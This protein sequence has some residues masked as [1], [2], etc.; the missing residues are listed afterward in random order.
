VQQEHRA[1]D[2]AALEV[3]VRRL[4]ERR[5][6][7]SDE[8]RLGDAGDPGQRGDGERLG[9]AAVHRVA[10]AEQPAVAL[11]DGTAHGP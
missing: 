4:A 11:L 3:A 8:V 9:V 7:G 10:R 6:E 1:L 5:A 2:P